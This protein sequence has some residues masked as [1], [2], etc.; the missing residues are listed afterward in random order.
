MRCKELYPLPSHPAPTI[1]GNLPHPTPRPILVLISLDPNI[2]STLEDDNGRDVP[3]N[4]PLIVEIK[5]PRSRVIMTVVGTDYKFKGARHD[6]KNAELKGPGG[7][8]LENLHATTVELLQG[9][10]DEVSLYRIVVE[11]TDDDTI[12]FF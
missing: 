11:F 5:G 1:L 9:T 4:G 12:Q 6:H 2:P 10:L 3:L 8:L 7:D